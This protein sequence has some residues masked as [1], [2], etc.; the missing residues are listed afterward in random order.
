LPHSGPAKGQHR[1]V[2]GD[3]KQNT[4]LKTKEGQK[5]LSK[6]LEKKATP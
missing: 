6:E 4:E 2:E 1:R 3:P 5:Q